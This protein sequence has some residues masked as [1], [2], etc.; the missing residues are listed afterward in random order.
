M[1]NIQSA[2]R[3]RYGSAIE[4]PSESIAGRILTLSRIGP[5]LPSLPAGIYSVFIYFSGIHVVHML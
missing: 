2:N 4:T 5:L 3:S 1:E